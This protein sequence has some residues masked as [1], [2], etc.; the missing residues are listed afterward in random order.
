M[1]KRL[2]STLLFLAL[3]LTLLPTAALAA[4]TRLK[5]VDL[6]IDL[7]KAGE[8]NEM[9]TEVAIK[10]FKSGSIDLLANGAGIL[11]TEWQGDDVET[12][13]GYAFRAGTTYLV[14]IKL[15]FDPAKGY[16]ANYKTVGGENL[17]GPDTFS[18]T[19][20]GVPA[21][22]RTSAQY[23]PTLQ[24]SLTIAG[25]R[26]TEAE[27][28]ELNADLA[29]KT[30]LLSQAKRAMATPRTQAEANA[31][32]YE[33]FA[34]SVTV[35]TDPSHVLENTDSIRTLILDADKVTEDTCF[36]IAY[37]DYL[38][39][40][41]LSD[42]VDVYQFI[43]AMDTYLW[44]PIA[45][46]Y[47]WERQSDMPF[48]TAET[49]VFIPESAVPALKAAQAERGYKI[50]YTIKTYSGADVYAAQ[51]A[52]AA[53]AKDN[54]CTAHQYTM[55]IRTADRVYTYAQACQYARRYY[56]SCAI[57]G[58][59][60][61]N[62]GHV[63][64][65]SDDTAL[66]LQQEKLAHSDN[67]EYPTAE[68]YI[69]VNAAGEH[70]YW[71]SC[72]YCG[73]SHRYLQQHLTARDVYASGTGLSLK[74]YQEEVNAT[75]KWEETQALNT[76]E[77]YPGTFTLAQKSSA[78]TSSWAQSDVNLALNDNLLDAGLLGSDYTKNITRLQFCSVAVRLAEELTGKSITPAAANTF[79]DTNNAYVLKA[80]AAGITTGT[81]TSAFS[82][83][84]TLTRQ[85]MAAFLY[86]T[87]RYVEKNSGY[88]YTSYTSKLASYTDNAQ[89]QGWAKESMAFMNALDLVK[90]TTATT[91]NP[92]GKCTIEQAVAV[93]ERSVYAH[94]IGWYQAAPVTNI[95]D[96]NN[97]TGEHE[98]RA[99]DYTSFGSTNASLHPGDLVWVTGKLTGV[100]NLLAT[101]P[102]A[103]VED[104]IYSAY[105]PGINPYTGQSMYLR[106]R[107]LIPV[108]G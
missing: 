80:Y 54:W 62:A 79:T 27:K 6:V 42:K 57:C 108:R 49:T 107:D 26:Y 102:E 68:A 39:E 15:A 74:Q 47:R 98:R 43:Q 48:Y 95:Y 44:L 83:N 75:L 72:E 52:G 3:A 41:W 86:R 32:Q 17:V 21:T 40:L 66:M 10:S 73:H 84:D 53:A 59:C 8:P 101:A 97:S 19:V 96:Y 88:S 103:T 67:G 2:L 82:P 28:S 16:C 36:F 31:K 105:I 65:H 13:D 71:L 87:L 92:N 64:P 58:K 24:V 100:S 70:V 23:Y 22:V 50:P 60:E 94:Q 33:N 91:L 7:P 61:H 81:S 34:T 56:W 76:T 30:D 35:M 25:E 51:K 14:N 5:S 69:G 63:A 45:G 93:A 85:Q 18:A 37:A 9:E 46:V 78:K 77:L 4:P 20:N 55:Q 104:C 38:K 1:K 29:R 12:D 106:Y 11:Y 99:G 89:V 90:G